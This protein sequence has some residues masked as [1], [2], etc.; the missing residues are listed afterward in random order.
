MARKTWK[1]KFYEKIDLLTENQKFA[2]N[3]IFLPSVR[4]VSDYRAF[5]AACQLIDRTLEK[6]EKDG[7]KPESKE[8]F[9]GGNDV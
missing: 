3:K 7:V 1:Q 2:L 8:W 9:N 6:N 5:R 4:K